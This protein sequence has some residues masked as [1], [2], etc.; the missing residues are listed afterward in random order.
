MP[1]DTDESPDKEVYRTWDKLRV[2][3][4]HAFSSMP[5]PQHLN[6]FT[7]PGAL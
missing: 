2:W 6:G 3:S 1:K 5:P 7:K 4:F